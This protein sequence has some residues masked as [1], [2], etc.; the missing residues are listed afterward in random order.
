MRMMKKDLAEGI[1]PKRHKKQ[2]EFEL[3]AQICRYLRLQYPKVIFLSDTVAS[4]KLTLG[5]AT[6]NKQLQKSGFK[7]PDLLILEPN[8]DYSGL[9]IE[10]KTKDPHKLNGDIRKDAHL[11]GQEKAIKILN[12]KGYYSCF[13]WDFEMTKNIIDEYLKK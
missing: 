9:M 3:Q 12:E 10:L 11:I 8:G 1:R 4:V 5:Q 2:P 13:S 6:R 7:I